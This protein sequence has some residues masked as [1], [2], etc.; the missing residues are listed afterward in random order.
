MDNKI[1][2]HTFEVCLRET[3]S[4]DAC[5]PITTT[6]MDLESVIRRWAKDH[7]L[8]HPTVDVVERTVSY[9]DDAPTWADIQQ[10]FRDELDNED[11]YGIIDGLVRSA[12]AKIRSIKFIR[13]QT[14]WG[15][16]KSKGLYENWF[17]SN[18]F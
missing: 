8:D 11:V 13:S 15:L 3:P 14:G 1:I 12:T 5:Y 16:T 9:T 17:F 10:E 7:G 4:P 2:R 18:A 6:G